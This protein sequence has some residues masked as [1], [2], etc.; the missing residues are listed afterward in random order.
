MEAFLLGT[1]ILLIAIILFMA[2]KW[3]K[4]IEISDV[5]PEEDSPRNRWLKLQN[6]GGK[7]VQKENDRIKLKIVK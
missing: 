2:H 5:A 3:P 4:T 1:I 6:E 7:Y